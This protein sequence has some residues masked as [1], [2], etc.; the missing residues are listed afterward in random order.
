MPLSSQQTAD[1]QK[2]FDP[3]RRR[4]QQQEAANLQTQKDALARRAAASGGG[5]SGAFVKQEQ[6]ASDASARR[7]QDANEGVDAQFQAA[8]NQER[9]VQAGRDFAREERIGS[10]DFSAKQG[11]IQRKWQSGEAATQRGWQT[12][13][14]MSSQ[15]FSA[16]ER[17]AAQK[18]ADKQRRYG[19]RFQGGQAAADRAIRQQAMAIQETQFAKQLE[20]AMAQFDWEKIV[21]QWNK[22]LADRIQHSNTHSSGGFIGQTADRWGIT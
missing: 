20:L 7:L 13:E 16:S 18:F 10:Q 6:L 5:P 17:Y 3:M 4:L 8:L 21:D 15:D 14:R 11:A 2:Q 22:D 19:E 1:I 12:G 9:Q